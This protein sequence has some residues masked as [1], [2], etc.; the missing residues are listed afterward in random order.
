MTFS[1][2]LAV[3]T[4][5]IVS[6]EMGQTCPIP[7]QDARRLLLVTAPTM[8]T[9]KAT[10]QLF[11]RDTRSTPWHAVHVAEPAVLGR[12]GMAWGAGFGNLAREGEPVKTEGDMRTPAGFYSIGRTFGFGASSREGYLHIRAG[13]TVCVD[14]P[15]SSAYNTITSRAMIKPTVHAEN[16]GSVDLY[17]RGLVIDYPT[18]AVAKAG[19]CI[20]IHVWR[21]ADRGTAGCVALPEPRV[22]VFQK[23]AARGVVIGILP[24]GAFERLT[25]C[26]PKLAPKAVLDAS[27]RHVK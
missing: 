11:E 16:M 5:Q 27:S 19:S 23:L 14:D 7:L 8:N 18:D 9:L 10:I 24:Q 20:F 25:G 15:S 22:S 12:S 1:L 2:A 17:R 13:E 6:S 3:L 26:L 21:A 4:A